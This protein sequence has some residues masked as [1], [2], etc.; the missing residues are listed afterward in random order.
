MDIS[1]LKIS[2]SWHLFGYIQFILGEKTT[3]IIS[4][5]NMP[6]RNKVLAMYNYFPESGF[7]SLCL[8]EIKLQEVAL[9]EKSGF[10]GCIYSGAVTVGQNYAFSPQNMSGKRE[11]RAEVNSVI[12]NSVNQVKA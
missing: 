12:K 4:V 8:D 3:E 1:A 2:A 5:F 7:L 11:A 6:K 9:P 10:S